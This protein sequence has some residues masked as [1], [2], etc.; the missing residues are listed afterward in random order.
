MIAI[1]GQPDAGRRLDGA[2]GGVMGFALGARL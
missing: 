2:R 1:A